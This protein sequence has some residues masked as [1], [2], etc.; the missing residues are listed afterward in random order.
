MH[1]AQR[2]AR[3][4]STAIHLWLITIAS[5]KPYKYRKIRNKNARETGKSNKTERHTRMSE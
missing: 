5:F 3:S 2:V 1:L 4:S